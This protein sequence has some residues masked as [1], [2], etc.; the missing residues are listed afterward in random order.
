MHGARSTS[1]GKVA[2]QQTGTKTKDEAE[3]RRI[4]ETIDGIKKQT[5]TDVETILKAMETEASQ[6]FGDGLAAAE[7][8][9]H[10]TFE[11]EKGGIGN[12]LTNWGDDWKN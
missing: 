1:I 8:A 10:R 4:T 9:Y 3:R 7:A 11:E 6:I 5:R 12:W 2:S